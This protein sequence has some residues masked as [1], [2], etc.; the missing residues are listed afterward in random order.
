MCAR[1][2]GSLTSV[3]LAVRRAH[4]LVEKASVGGDNEP[5]AADRDHILKLRN[6]V[7]GQHHGRGWPVRLIQHPNS[8]K[9]M[10]FGGAERD[11]GRCL[12]GDSADL[13]R[14]TLDAIQ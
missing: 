3:V 8:G 5:G 7:R 2:N 1:I 4:F 10:R 14:E 9:E 6:F 11:D 12:S 13:A